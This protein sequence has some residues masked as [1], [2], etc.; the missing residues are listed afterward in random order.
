MVHFMWNA[1]SLLARINIEAQFALFMCDSSR[2]QHPICE[3]LGI[4]CWRMV[5]FCNECWF[6][7]LSLLCYENKYSACTVS[8][9]RLRT[10][11]LGSA[12]KTGELILPEKE[13]LLLW[14]LKVYLH[15]DKAFQS[16]LC[17]HISPICDKNV[18]NSKFVH[19]WVIG[20]ERNVC[21]CTF[22]RCSVITQFAKLATGEQLCH[23]CTHRIL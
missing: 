1:S 7:I 11:S 16:E 6:S 22:N 19:F 4:P 15:I 20:V 18:H 9:R 5:Y 13:T 3:S 2:S 17:D 14:Y 21:R 8:T 12:F 23:R 10:T